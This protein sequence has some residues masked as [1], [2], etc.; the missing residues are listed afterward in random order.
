MMGNLENQNKIGLGM[1]YRFNNFK[2]KQIM[3][4]AQNYEALEKMLKHVKSLIKRRDKLYKI[5]TSK[6][7]ILNLKE[8]QQPLETFDDGNQIPIID[9]PFED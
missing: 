3:K 2:N 8:E 5:D 9:L 7:Q 4:Q 6:Q 1:A